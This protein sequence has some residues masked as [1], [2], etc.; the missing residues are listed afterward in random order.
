M[1]Q[2]RFAVLRADISREQGNVERLVAEA[3]VWQ[4][5]LTDWPDTVRVRTAGG[6][7]HDFY[8]G[9][10]RIF[11]YIAVRIDG[12]LPLVRTGISS[13]CSGWRRVLKQCAQPSSITKQP[14][15]LM[16]IYAFGICSG[17]STVLAW[18]GS[19]VTVVE[20]AAGIV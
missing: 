2:R 4:S 5:Q 18:S 14:G 11:R 15:G 17:T 1:Q 7:L 13:C 8:C 3:Q 20:R 12:D 19:A 9:V 6:I 10:E 16:S